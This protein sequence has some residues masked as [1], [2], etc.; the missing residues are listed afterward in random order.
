MDALENAARYTLSRTVILRHLSI[1]KTLTISTSHNKTLAPVFK[2]LGHLWLFEIDAPLIRRLRAPEVRG[3]LESLGDFT[4]PDDN[5]ESLEELAIDFCQLL[6]GP[7]GHL[8]PIQSVWEQDQFQGDAATSMRRFT[9]LLPG[10]EAPGAILDHVGVQLDYAS[11]LM[12]QEEVSA[13]AQEILERFFN[14]HLGWTGPLFKAITAQATTDLYRGLAKITESL[15][16]TTN[17]TF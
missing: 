11:K 3:L 4:L 15:I 17:A 2:L 13:V 10:Y 9:E 8:S 6:V 7:K 12:E 16:E 5:A 14:D 1:S